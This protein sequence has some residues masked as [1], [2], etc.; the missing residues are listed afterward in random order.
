MLSIYDRRV[1]PRILL[2]KGF[3]MR[4][5][6]FSEDCKP[7]ATPLA[8]L[9]C[10][11]AQAYLAYSGSVSGHDRIHRDPEDPR[12]CSGLHMAIQ[13]S[14]VCLH[15]FAGMVYL[16]VTYCAF[17]Y[18]RYLCIHTL[19]T[20]EQTRNTN[21]LV[22]CTCIYIY[23]YIYI[24]VCVCVYIQYVCSYVCTHAVQ[25]YP[26]ALKTLSQLDPVAASSNSGGS[27]RK[28]RVPAA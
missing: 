27:S 20:N 3:T 23:I 13:T 15:I 5:G 16:T 14:H 9:S 17:P 26:Y 7:L 22:L 8:A 24:C 1:H 6:V 11:Q 12:K 19:C 10:R 25:K 18:L 28:S 21:T 4:L 2:L